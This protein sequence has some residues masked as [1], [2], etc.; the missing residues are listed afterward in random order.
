M[1]HPNTP[2]S[3]AE[4][5]KYHAI[6]QLSQ[7]QIAA[8]E[9]DNFAV[10]QALLT[11]KGKLIT[12]LEQAGTLLESDASFAALVERIRSCEQR[13]ETLLTA[14]LN[15]TRLRLGE[16][17]ERKTARRAYESAERRR[18]LSLAPTLAV[19]DTPRLFDLHS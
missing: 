12:N 15:Q 14:R 9:S 3:S 10:F 2:Q 18:S 8:L 6:L 5:A 13:S 17:R 19:A 4:R 1:T 7:Q 11:A 16:L